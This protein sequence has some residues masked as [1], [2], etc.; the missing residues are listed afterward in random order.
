MAQWWGPQGCT[1]PVCDLDVRPGGRLHIVIR[2][3]QGEDYP[4]VGE[5][6]EI[7]RPSRLVMR[8]HSPGLR[9]V[10]T[11]LFD[12]HFGKTTV[13]LVQRFESPADAAAHRE[14]GAGQGWAGTFEKLDA[15]L[16]RGSAA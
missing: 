15:L 4:I 8:R 2:S 16:V 12:D 13:T 9:P 7:V 5:Y 3:P 11:V 1:V 14:S 10:T 6:V